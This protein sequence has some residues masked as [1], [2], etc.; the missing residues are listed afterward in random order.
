MKKLKLA[1]LL[2]C[3]AFAPLTVLAS[4]VNLN[5][6]SASELEALAYPV[7]SD[8]AAAWAA[9][10]ADQ[11]V[12]DYL[13]FYSADFVPPNGAARR[14]WEAYRRERLT[15]PDSISI[16]LSDVSEQVLDETRTRVTFAQAYSAGAYS[17]QV[18]KTLVMV[19]ED[20]TWKILSETSEVL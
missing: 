16:V 17:D 3:L 10:W 5:T 4:Q 9:A 15:A 19:R 7:A 11:R 13:S 20:G 18:L 8:V 1:V 2:F 14:A 12:E 6:A